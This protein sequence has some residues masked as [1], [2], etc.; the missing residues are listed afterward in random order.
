MK[1][2]LFI[3][4]MATGL[5]LNGQ[6]K[7]DRVQII[8]DHG[9]IIIELY[10]GSA[11]LTCS[12]FLLYVDAGHFKESSFYRTVTMDNQPDNDI[13][14]EVIQGGLSGSGKR[15]GIAA[16]EHETT[17]VSGLKHLDGTISMARS[18]PGTA[19]SEFFICINDQPS[20]D[21]GGLR[22]P[23][24]QGFAAFGKV[25]YGMDI[26]KKIQNSPARGQN[27]TPRIMIKN[28]S[29]IE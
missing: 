15:P 1:T 20:L 29:R 9:N 13:K 26:V 7:K 10:P 21:Y 27:L 8:T 23:D 25:I 3:L 18:N 17:E 5:N 6:Q 19:S 24:G 28:I 2:V 12:N 14:I 22:N 11:P 16:I 4:M